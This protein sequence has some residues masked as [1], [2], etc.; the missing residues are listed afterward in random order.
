MGKLFMMLFFNDILTGGGVESAERT[1]VVWNS[2][3]PWKMS[4]I[5]SFIILNYIRVIMILEYT[6][7]LLP[8]TYFWLPLWDTWKTLHRNHRAYEQQR[9]YTYGRT[10]PQRLYPNYLEKTWKTQLFRKYYWIFNVLTSP[11]CANRLTIKSL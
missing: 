8:I 1:I 4:Y 2:N 11:L 10:C 6:I 7:H 5:P 3:S 9:L